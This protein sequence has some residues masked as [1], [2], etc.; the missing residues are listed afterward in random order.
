MLGGMT[1]ATYLDTLDDDELRDRLDAFLEVLGYGFREH[2]AAVIV[3]VPF[4]AILRHK[5]M[6]GFASMVEAA[7]QV[8]Q[9]KLEA[10]AFRRAMVSEKSDRLLMFLL[11]N[12]DPERWKLRQEVTAT[13]AVDAADAILAAR[14]RAGIT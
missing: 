10:E 6:P 2:E 7:K 8:D 13:V 11:S 3:G 14:K 12:L 5:R 1:D 4:S 9:G